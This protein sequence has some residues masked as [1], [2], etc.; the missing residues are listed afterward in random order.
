M[1]LTP[2]KQGT[3]KKEKK[4]I[5]ATGKAPEGFFYVQSCVS[6][7]IQKLL[8]LKFSNSIL[9]KGLIYLRTLS[10]SIVS[11]AMVSAFLTVRFFEFG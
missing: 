8:A 7:G 6:E 4:R 5:L 11:E 2:R 1:L 9:S 3:G 10:K